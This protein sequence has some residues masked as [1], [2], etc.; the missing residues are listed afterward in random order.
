MSYIY[1]NI[2]LFYRKWI[3]CCKLSFSY[4][5][6]VMIGAVSFTSM[7]AARRRAAA[8][9]EENHVFAPTL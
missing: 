5:M 1:Y 6:Y 8:L 3:Q 7:S 2:S 4:E 9:E